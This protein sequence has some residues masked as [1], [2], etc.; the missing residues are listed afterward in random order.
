M[1][2][3]LA[4]LALPLIEIA[5]FVVVGGSIGLWATLAWVVLSAVLGV[6]IL[7][8]VARMGAIS[9]D[10]DVKALRDP[11]SP[12]AGRALT[13]LAAGLLILPGFFTDTLG[14]LLLLPPVQALLVRVFSRRLRQ[15]ATVHQSSITIDGDWVE[16]DSAPNDD[17]ASGPDAAQPPS[18][19]TRH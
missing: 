1:W 8:R 10:R 19:W 12:I 7:K 18:G 17:R 3:M 15:T 5:L 9:F 13:I 2:L 4:V 14:L 16:V 6:L 11:M